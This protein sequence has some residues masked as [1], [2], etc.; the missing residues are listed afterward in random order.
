MPLKPQD[1]AVWI[2][3]DSKRSI[4]A[5]GKVRSISPSGKTCLVSWGDGEDTICRVEKE[6]ITV[7]QAYNRKIPPWEHVFDARPKNRT[8][9]RVKRMVGIDVLHP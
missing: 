1:R 5:S 8:P 9:D 4:G 7:R 3:S 2:G 6:V